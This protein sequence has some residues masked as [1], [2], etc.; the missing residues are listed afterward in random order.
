MNYRCSRAGA[1]TAPG[2]QSIPGWPRGRCAVL[3]KVRGEACGKLAL[4]DDEL[5]G[6]PYG[7]LEVTDGDDGV[8]RRSA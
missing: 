3:G 6:S 2:W 5:M 1:L 4:C 8:V 7:Q